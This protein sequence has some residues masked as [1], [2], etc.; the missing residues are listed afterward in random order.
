VRFASL[1][2]GSEGNALL[3]S[4]SADTTATHIILDCGFGPRELNRRLSRLAM[5]AEQLAGIIVTHEHSD[6]L[7]GVF[8]VARQFKL[9]V[10]LT[11]GSFESA[12]PDEA[13]GVEV[14]LC[15]DGYRFAIGDLEINPYTV[16]HDAREPVQYT[17]SDGRHKLGV[18]T[19]VGHATQH[20]ISALA[21]C[22]AL[23]LEFNHDSEMLARSAY[24]AWLKSRISGPFG[25]L[26]NDA[27]AGI[28]RELDK[29]HLHTLIAAHLS[30][31]N[32]SPD[33]AR[34]AIEPEIAETDIA[35]W[36]ADQHSGSEWINCAPGGAA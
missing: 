24:P 20:L 32:N 23:L 10:W 8:Q 2:S 18:L 33:L 12:S 9:P 11:H 15:R 7:G 25:H 35:L 26:S 21:G 1:G 3:I 27:A 34:A 28:L 14:H 4:A 17:I 31:R 22:H 6:H 30:Q 19:D 5:S 16:P 13:L 36:V 29:T